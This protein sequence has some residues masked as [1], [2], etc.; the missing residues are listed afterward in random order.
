[1]HG[2]L[3]SGAARRTGA[4]ASSKRRSETR[5]EIRTAPF[6]WLVSRVCGIGKS[7]IRRGTSCSRRCRAGVTDPMPA[8][9]SGNRAGSYSSFQTSSGAAAADRLWSK[10]GMGYSWVCC[11]LDDRGARPARPRRWRARGGLDQRADRRAA[12]IDERGDVASAGLPAVQRP[13][14]PL[15]GCRAIR[16]GAARPARCRRGRRRS[17]PGPGSSGRPAWRGS[18]SGRPARA[19]R[20]AA[21]SRPGRAASPGQRLGQPQPGGGPADRGAEVQGGGQVC[22]GGR[23]VAAGQGEQS[24]FLPD[25][26]VELGQPDP[27]GVPAAASQAWPPRHRPSRRRMAERAV[28]A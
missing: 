23:R 12:Q 27:V 20:R 2:D 3:G 8:H 14:D 21:R 4:A 5:Q 16:S 11:R 22:G 9:H 18:R 26:A 17:G 25:E 10:V 6:S 7:G 19:R 24:A 28:C 1:M 15:P 13:G